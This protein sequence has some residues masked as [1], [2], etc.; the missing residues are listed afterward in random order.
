MRDEARFAAV[1]WLI[2]IRQRHLEY[3]ASGRAQVRLHADTTVGVVEA[4]RADDVQ[5]L[6]GRRTPRLRRRPGRDQLFF[7]R[8]DG[9][10]MEDGHGRNLRGQHRH[11]GS[12]TTVRAH[13]GAATAASAYSV[14]NPTMTRTPRGRSCGHGV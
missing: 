9:G 5:C 10:S 3:R 2:P 13:S 1:E 14:S 7:G 4:V 6:V 11:S 12:M 8:G